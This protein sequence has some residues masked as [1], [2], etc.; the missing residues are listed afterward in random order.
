MKGRYLLIAAHRVPAEQYPGRHD[1][2][3]NLTLRCSSCNN[4]QRDLTDQQWAEAKAARSM[5]RGRKS[6]DRAGNADVGDNDQYD[7][8]GRGPQAPPV[9]APDPPPP[10][11]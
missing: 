9:R 10:S 6:F 2:L 11:R 3:Q 7:A 8:C 4:S 5:A 1:D